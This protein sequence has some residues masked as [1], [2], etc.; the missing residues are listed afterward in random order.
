VTDPLVIEHRSNPTEGLVNIDILIGRWADERRLPIWFP[1][2]SLVQH[3]GNESSI[4]SDPDSRAI[5]ERRANRFAGDIDRV[6]PVA[7]TDSVIKDA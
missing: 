7:P 3:I 2:P 6:P 4:W 1:S 5:G